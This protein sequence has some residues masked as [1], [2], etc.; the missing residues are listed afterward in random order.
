M[1]IAEW[2][3]I[4]AIIGGGIGWFFGGFDIIFYLLVLFV[5][6]DYITGLMCAAVSHSI[7]SAKGMQGIMKKVLI[8]LWVGLGHGLDLLL[9]DHGAPLRTAVIFFY[10]S[11]E[12]ISI[13]E[14]SAMLGLPIPKRLKTLLLQLGEEEHD[15]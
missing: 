14:N 9:I 1:S 10:L 6:V 8:F 2:K 12:G 13:L 11:N 4:L 15:R 5:A 7:S 3:G